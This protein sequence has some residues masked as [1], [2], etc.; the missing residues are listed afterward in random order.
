MLKIPTWMRLLAVILSATGCEEQ[1]RAASTPPEPLPTPA[2]IALPSPAPDPGSPRP[3][4][5]ASAP[6]TVAKVE[7]PRGFG[8]KRIYLD[9]G[10]G[11]PDALATPGSP[12]PLQASTRAQDPGP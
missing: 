1:T 7:F 8:R 11:A 10:H 3:W 12:R 6:L 5:A 4:P 9:A 2:V